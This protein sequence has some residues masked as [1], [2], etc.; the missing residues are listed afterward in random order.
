VFYPVVLL[1]LLTAFSASAQFPTLIDLS[2]SA[3]DAELIGAR[4][5]D[6]SG[7]ALATGDIDGDGYLDLV[8][9]ACN[10]SP[11]QGQRKGEAY[12]LWG[13]TFNSGPTDLLNASAGVSRIFGN[14][15]D[16]GLYCQ[17]A[18]GDFNNDGK[19]DIILGEPRGFDW[20]GRT[21]VIFG[22]PDFPDTLDLGGTP[23]GVTTLRGIQWSGGWLGRGVCACDVTGDGYDEVVLAATALEYSETYILLGG[24]AFL[25]TYDMSQ[26]TPGVTRL[27]DSEANRAT[28]KAMACKDIDGD[29][30]DDLLLGAPGNGPPTRD[31]RAFL[32]YGQSILPD[33]I[34]LSENTVRLKRVYPEYPHGSLGQD[35]AIGDVNGD[36]REDLLISA[37]Q[38]DPLGCENCGEVYVFYDADGLPDSFSVNSLDVPAT[39]LIG[40]E[41]FAWH[42]VEI[43]C[44]D[45][46]ND[47]YEEI[48][49]SSW[50]TY[51]RSRTIV[52][53]GRATMPDSVFLDGDTAVVSRILEANQGDQL[54]RD[55]AAGDFNH[56]DTSDLVLGAQNTSPLSR[57]FA[58]NT[59]VLFGSGTVT[60]IP[61]VPWA[62]ETF[63]NPFSESTHKEPGTVSLTI[64][65][66]VGQRVA[67]LTTPF[68]TV[69]RQRI[70]WDGVD[71]RG[72]RLP[73]GVYF[74]RL[75]AGK[76]TQT[77]KVVI[78]R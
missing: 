45:L 52:V 49:T 16:D 24:A 71:E 55:L 75:Q 20:D 58:G 76:S 13:N 61:R 31:G 77:R 17:V 50:P 64:Y 22:R 62:P 37:Q 15:G 25:E 40:A 67:E 28:G 44:A 54:G 35:V 63:P 32:L 38:A 47:G 46:T 36:G 60:A 34:L 53:Y 66:V 10:A 70:L 23:T 69:G 43:L 51:S 8:M 29:G 14:L 30:N 3:A 6:F 42:G 19:D 48:V 1:I 9:V 18:T 12:I 5:Y 26:T 33:T 39:R 4:A 2:L 27:I 68:Q 59:Y 74:Y 72:R 57:Q 41:D 78:V 73:S 7:A 65:N 21:Y 11:L 56:D